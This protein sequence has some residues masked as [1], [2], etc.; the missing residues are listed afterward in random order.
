[1]TAWV[2]SFFLTILKTNDSLQ[3]WNQP[4]GKYWHLVAAGAIS[5]NLLSVAV[6]LEIIAPCWELLQCG[7]EKVR[8][9]K[10][11]KRQGKGREGRMGRGFLTEP[12]AVTVRKDCYAIFTE[13]LRPR[14]DFISHSCGTAKGNRRLLPEKWSKGLSGEKKKGK[15]KKVK[16]V[17]EENVWVCGIWDVER[18]TQSYQNTKQ[19][20]NTNTALCGNPPCHLFTLRFPQQNHSRSIWSAAGSQSKINRAGFSGTNREHKAFAA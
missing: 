2:I 10:G 7:K 5:P 3:Q 12:G 8:K 18:T 20:Q 4:C 1:M 17:G 6:S 19:Q 14:R 13:A 11:V 9:R 15:K 16:E